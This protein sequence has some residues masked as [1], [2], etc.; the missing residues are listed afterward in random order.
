MNFDFTEEQ[1]ALGDSLRRY[2]RNEYGFEQRQRHARSELGYSEAA[3]RTYAEMGL[4]AVAFPEEVGGLGGGMVDVMGV[5]QALG[6]SLALEPFVSTVVLC[7]SLIDAAGSA[8]QRRE[9]LALIGAGE[10]KIALAHFEPG[11][12]YGVESVSTSAER[13]GDGFRLRGH[14]SVVLDAPSADTLIVSARI[15]DRHH[16]QDAANGEGPVALFLVNPKSPGVTV[17][18]YVTHDGARAADVFLDQVEVPAAARLGPQADA[19]AASALHH[20]LDLANIALCCEAV[21]IMAALNANTLDYVKTRKQFGV[22]IGSF[23]VIQHR[24]ADMIVAKEQADAITTLAAARAADAEPAERSRLASAAKALV[25]QQARFVGQQAVQL[26][27]G[28]GLAYEYS[29]GHYFKRLT[30]IGL[31]FGDADTHLARFSATLL[32]A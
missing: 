31:T 32:D 22:P 24:L 12:R 17:R 10:L 19:D 8:Q 25:C 13:H 9:L 29:T 5:M 16:I 11:R 15:Q 3:W 26:H 23:Q 6:S 20:A 14:K 4:L 2:L 21:G 18:P 30:T 27:G 28:M 7:G 1:L